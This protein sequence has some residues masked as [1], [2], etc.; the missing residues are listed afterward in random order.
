MSCRMSVDTP[1]DLTCRRIRR[2]QTFLAGDPGERLQVFRGDGVDMKRRELMEISEK[3]KWNLTMGQAFRTCPY[4]HS[5]H[6][7]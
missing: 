3:G 5:F 2:L 4:E 7:Q 1:V 6:L